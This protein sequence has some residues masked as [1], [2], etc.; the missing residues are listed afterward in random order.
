M[1]KLLCVLL[2][3]C[4]L[5]PVLGLTAAADEPAVYSETKIDAVYPLVIVRGMDFS[6]GLRYHAG[7][8]DERVVNVPANLSAEGV[9]KALGRIGAAFVTR[10]EAGAVDE[11][12]SFAASLAVSP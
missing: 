11:I 1:R 2:A 8:A 9:F 3:A 7:G 10:G 4:L 6:N 12:I 5:L